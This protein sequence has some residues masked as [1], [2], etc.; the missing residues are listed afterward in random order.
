FLLGLREFDAEDIDL[1]LY[2]HSNVILSG[3]LRAMSPGSDLF[4]VYDEL[5]GEWF[6][7]NGE[8]ES[9]VL[10]EWEWPLSLLLSPH[11]VLARINTYLSLGDSRVE[12][13]ENVSISGDQIDVESISSRCS[14]H[15]DSLTCI[16]TS[17]SVSS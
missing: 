5:D 7:D 15:E 4:S 1:S 12:M 11:F 3:I 13:E 14:I 9:T 8:V 17:S 16:N 10:L 2:P 6:I